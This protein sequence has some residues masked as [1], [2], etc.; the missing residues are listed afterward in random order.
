M[1]DPVW[2]YAQGDSEKGPLTTAQ[3][4]ALTAAGKVRRDDF[5]WKE[6]METW[7]PARDLPELF[8]SE[9]QSAAQPSPGKGAVRRP[10][11]AAPVSS[12]NPTYPHY[13][14]LGQLT[15]SLG[16][17]TVL[18]AKGCDSLSDRYV[19]RLEALSSA[20]QRRFLRRWQ[21][22]RQL[23]SEQLQS[24]TNQREPEAQLVLQQLQQLNKAKRAEATQ[25]AAADW[26]DQHAAAESA[27]DNNLVWGYWREAA[28][29][30]GTLILAV[31][32]LAFSFTGTGPERWICLAIL[33]A[34]LYSVYLSSPPSSFRP[35]VPAPRL[36][37]S[38]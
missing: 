7:A 24:F 27:R 1:S 2:Y 15:I 30:A 23:L 14:P 9:P 13:R 16:L 8:D 31:G 21:L 3:I 34:I 29:Q 20:N 11:S 25:L 35:A 12:R 37:N 6:G 18:L 26:R 22:Q 33:A 10:T 19:A 4:K 28:F 32:L 36:F 38:E 5:V 17:L